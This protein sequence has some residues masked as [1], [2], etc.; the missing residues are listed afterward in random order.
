MAPVSTDIRRGW[1]ALIVRSWHLKEPNDKWWLVKHD[2]I[3]Y[4]LYHAVERPDDH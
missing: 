1:P 4:H 3:F 2:G